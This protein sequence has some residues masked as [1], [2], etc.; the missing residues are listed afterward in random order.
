MEH[1]LP[2]LFILLTGFAFVLNILG[3][4]QIIP[5]FLTLPLLFITIYLTIFSFTQKGVYKGMR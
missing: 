4:M 1:L 2:F 3:L 5:V